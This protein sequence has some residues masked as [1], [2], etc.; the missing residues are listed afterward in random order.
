MNKKLLIPALL[1]AAVGVGAGEAAGA[2][3]EKPAQINLSLGATSS[4]SG[5]YVPIVLIA[6]V[7]NK[8]VPGLRITVVETGAAIDNWVR[9][10]RGDIDFIGVTSSPAAM[11]AYHGI[12]RFKG[13]PTPAARWLVNWTVGEQRM[14]VRADSD[15]HSV[16]DLDGK[17][18][19]FGIPGSGTEQ[20]AQVVFD[21]IGIKPDRALGSLGDAINLMKD[22]KIVGLMKFSPPTVLD[23]AIANI[24]AR[25]P[26]RILSY[27]EDETAA[28]MKAFPGSIRIEVAAGS[29]VGAEEQGDIRSPLG[30]LAAF[31]VPAEAMNP[32]FT[33]DLVYK[34]AKALDEHWDVVAAGYPGAKQA[35]KF[36]D[37]INYTADMEKVTGLKPIPLHAGVVKYLKEKGIDVPASL[38]PPEFGK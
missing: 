18:F 27:T 28:V 29:I 15:V 21:T 38:V 26:V 12:G 11:N 36:V 22:N 31:A 6:R 8:H 7:L 34:M 5:S 2:S 30:T 19:W 20:A 3:H 35:N 33:E 13:D 16:K 14:V 10:K 17:K 37:F 24:R 9:T 25:T 1:I 23:S 4:T 32:V